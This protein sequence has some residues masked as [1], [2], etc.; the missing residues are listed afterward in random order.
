MQAHLSALS[1]SPSGPRGWRRGPPGA[2][3]RPARRRSGAWSRPGPCRTR[4]RSGGEQRTLGTARRAASST[5]W[6][7]GRL[8]WIRPLASAA[9][10]EPALA[11][12]L[13]RHGIGSEVPGFY[14]VPAAKKRLQPG[15]SL[16]L[17]ARMVPAPQR[18]RQRHHAA[19]SAQELLPGPRDVPRSPHEHHRPPGAVQTLAM[20]MDSRR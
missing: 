16:V 12:R 3:S 1:A 13:M 15:T 2:A 20:A 6:A 17:E 9:R 10:N 18:Q 19:A 7:L 14:Q 11:A 4:R 5:K 8:A